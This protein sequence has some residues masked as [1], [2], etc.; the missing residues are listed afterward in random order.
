MQIF[1]ATL[2]LYARA[3]KRSLECVRKNWI[4]SF[5]PI[6]YGVGLT[7]VA[8]AGGAIGNHRRTAVF[9]REGSLRKF[10]SLSDQ[11]YGRKRQG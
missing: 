7:I 8:F 5:A 2:W 9:D 6:A 11:K 10:G 1:Q 4:V 3:F